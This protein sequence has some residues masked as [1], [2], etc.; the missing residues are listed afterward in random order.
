MN[1]VLQAQLLQHVAATQAEMRS[2]NTGRR[3]QA[4][5]VRDVRSIVEEERR[6]GRIVPKK[7]DVELRA[8]ERQLQL[9]ARAAS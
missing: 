7:V 5:A 8:R 9:A 3:E 2:G 6:A 4:N 1:Q